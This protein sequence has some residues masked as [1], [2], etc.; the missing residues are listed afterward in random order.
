MDGSRLKVIHLYM[1]TKKSLETTTKN[2][3]S[4]AVEDED[5]DE[6]M[7]YAGC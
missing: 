7:D 5:E 2:C 3:L 4:I 6:A 1:K